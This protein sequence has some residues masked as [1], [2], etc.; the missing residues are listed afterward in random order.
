[1]RSIAETQG[2]EQVAF[3]VTSPSGSHIEDSISWIERLIRAFGSPNTI[4]ATE[5]C[6]WHKDFASR[7]TYGHDIGT[8]DFAG[9]DCVL[10]WGNN[11]T[12]TWLARATE[13]QRRLKRG[14]R[15]IV[16][17]PRPT[18]FAKRADQWLRVRPGTDQALAL[19]LAH[20]LIST[21]RFDRASSRIGRTGRCWCVRTPAVPARKRY[22][23]AGR[24]DV[25]AACIRETGRLL[26]YDTSRG[27]WLDQPTEAQLGA[28]LSAYRPP[29]AG[30]L[31]PAALPSISTPPRQRNIRPPAWMNHRHD[32]RRTAE[33]R[34]YPRGLRRSPT[35]RG[36]ASAQSVT[37]TQTNRPSRCSMP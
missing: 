34:R 28:Q 31:S 12:A 13:V 11:P 4:Y 18:A 22:G 37:A 29:I 35:T 1:M 7:L 30:P 20:L 2:P 24:P 3:S 36:T 23:G 8:P 6:N 26:P 27:I 5:I 15:M 17:D 14:A 25:L 32:R 33:C 10:L 19:G 21:G 9:T 16:V